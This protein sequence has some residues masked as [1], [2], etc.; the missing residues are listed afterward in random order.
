MSH[1]RRTL[2]V[3]RAS[4]AAIVLIGAMTTAA[5]Q[6]EVPSR[7]ETERFGLLATEVDIAACGLGLEQCEGFAE[8]SAAASNA[9]PVRIVVQVV[10]PR[11]IDD[12]SPASFDVETQF[13]PL[14]ESRVRLHDCDSC[15]EQREGGTYSLWVVPDGEA[16]DA[17]SYHLRVAVASSDVLLPALVRFDVPVIPLRP[18]GEPPTAAIVASPPSRQAFGYPVV[19]DGSVSFD[20]DSPITLLQRVYDEEQV[21]SIVLRVS[22]LP[23]SSGFCL[24]GHS[25]EPPE[26]FSSKVA[27]IPTYTIDC[28]N[29][30][31][32]AEAGPDQTAVITSSSVLVLLDGG[33]STDPDGRIDS[34]HWNCGNGTAPLPAGNPPIPWQAFCRYRAPGE[35]EA[36]LTVRDDGTGQID[37]ET[38]TFA[39]QQS[40]SDTTRVTIRE[41]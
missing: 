27:V 18:T 24:P 9:N 38:G 6:M 5:A 39:C 19:F 20:P 11:P 10:S 28:G 15:F 4:C 2:L 33:L 7:I 3:R 17:G 8:Q 12:L 21:L 26:R 1:V 25:P 23:I 35:Y 40:G 29:L 30:A 41:P 36:S 14:P 22:D 16:W 37:P 32:T 13:G 31:P 34:Y